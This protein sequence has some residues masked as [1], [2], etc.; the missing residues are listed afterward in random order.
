MALGVV[1]CVAACAIGPDPDLGHVRA[2]GLCTIPVG[3][4]VRDRDALQL[5]DLTEFGGSAK[6]VPGEPS[7]M[8][9]PLSS[10]SS[11]CLTVPSLRVSRTRSVKLK[12]LISQSM[13]APAS[14]YRR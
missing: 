7:M 14:A 13:A 9:P 2:R 3:W 11:P 6:L 10:S 12:A 8:T 1:H 4:Q 5:G